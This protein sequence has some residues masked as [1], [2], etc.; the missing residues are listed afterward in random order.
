MS[1]GEEENK[2]GATEGA[3]LPWCLSRLFE[4]GIWSRDWKADGY[5]WL[6]RVGC[7]VIGWAAG[8]R[9]PL[10]ESSAAS[11]GHS[12]ANLRSGCTSGR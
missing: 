12:T 10:P 5:I 7:G 9:D 11:A 4:K 8:G 6:V 1:V 2:A 3:N